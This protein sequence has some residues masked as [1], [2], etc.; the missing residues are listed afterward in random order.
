VKMNKMKRIAFKTLGC[1]LN[2]Y[3]TDALVTQFHNAGYKIVAFGEEADVTIINTCTVTNQSDQKSRNYINQAAAAH[4]DSVVVVA[5]CL[6]NNKKEQLEQQGN[7]TYVIDNERKNS[8]FPL[9]EAHFKN[10]IIH[11]DQLPSDVFG[12]E[13]VEKSLHTRTSIKVQD[14]CDN[15]C[16]F[17]I[18][19]KVRGR[20]ISRPLYDILENVKRVVHNGFKE[21][22]ITGVNIGRYN[23]EKFNFPMALEKILEV[24]GD[25][26]VRI[27]SIEPD[28][29]GKDF[30]D[31]FHHEKLAPHLHLCLQSGSDKVLMQMRRMYNVRSF[32]DI[33]ENFKH[34][35]PEFNFTTDII[36]GFPNETEEDF[37]KTIDI[38]KQAA[39]S[40]IHTFRYSVRNGTRAEKMDNHIPEKIKAERSKIIRDISAENKKRYYQE[41][42]GKSQRVLIE[43]IDKEG[44]A[45]GYGQHYIP[46][47]WKAGNV[48]RNTFEE[49]MLSEKVIEY[50]DN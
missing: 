24:P 20:A 42:T 27:S 13:T 7:I 30:A 21:I 34:I 38:A 46:V 40:H 49:L 12:F 25:F 16:T 36:V 14:G 19:P 45:R 2:Q 15:F 23:F 35:H 10:E 4:P 6:V 8:I 9:V 18:I 50:S 41:M 48:I 47:K 3:E 17:C 29:F 39:F 44:Y 33:V 26:R 1:R 11:P 28:G 5:G 31:L 32:M 43:R 22:V 37:Q